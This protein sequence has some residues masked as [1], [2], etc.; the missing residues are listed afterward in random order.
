MANANVFKDATLDEDKHEKVFQDAAR[1]NK[2]NPMP[3]DVV[4]LEN[5]YDFHNHFWGLV[6]EKT[7]SSMLWPKN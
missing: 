3:K 1:E 4:S 7:H 2:E 5:L 6:N